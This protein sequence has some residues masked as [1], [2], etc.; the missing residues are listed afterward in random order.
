M[1]GEGAAARPGRAYRRVRG[2]LSR[3]HAWRLMDDDVV[4]S[5]SV[6][7][8][9]FDGVRSFEQCSSCGRFIEGVCSHCGRPETPRPELTVLEEHQAALER[10]RAWAERIRSE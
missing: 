5:I 2:R 6:D 4:A 10:E 7:A 1:A 9:C 8:P 3:L